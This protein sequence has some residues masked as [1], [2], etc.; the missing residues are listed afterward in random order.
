MIKT[1]VNFEADGSFSYQYW[2][3]GALP[4]WLVPTPD[5][6]RLQASP[7]LIQSAILIHLF[8]NKKEDAP[9]GA[10]SF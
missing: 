3:T 7:S 2:S 10:P 1:P 8:C 6:Y 5:T 4:N 9:T